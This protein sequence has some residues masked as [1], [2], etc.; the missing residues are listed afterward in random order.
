MSFKDDILIE[1]GRKEEMNNGI[2]YREVRQYKTD[3]HI[4]R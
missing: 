2:N 1:G 3:Y 4:I